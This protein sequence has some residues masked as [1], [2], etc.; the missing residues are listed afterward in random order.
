METKQLMLGIDIEKDTMLMSYHV[1]SK[2]MYSEPVTVREKGNEQD[3]IT[4]SA[5]WDRDRQCWI[6]GT[7][8]M[9]FQENRVDS[10]FERYFADDTFQSEDMICSYE[11]IVTGLIRYCLQL[12][13]SLQ[14]RPQ[15]TRVVFTLHEVT[16]VIYQKLKTVMTEVGFAP[17][18]ICVQGHQESFFYYMTGQD[19]KLRA[20]AVLLLDHRETELLLYRMRTDHRTRPR[21][22]R[23]E[24]LGTLP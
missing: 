11:E 14:L 17:E 21:V 20:H 7:A 18:D 1:L 2:A 8:A 4:L 22:V 15:N 24:L 10:I 5:A 6:Y 19:A 16:Q 13:Q 12:L 3:G 9:N 23:T